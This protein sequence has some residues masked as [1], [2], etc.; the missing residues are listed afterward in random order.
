MEHD[1]RSKR[2]PQRYPQVHSKT[3][4]K[5]L[6]RELNILSQRFSTFLM[7]QASACFYLLSAG[8][9]RASQHMPFKLLLLVTSA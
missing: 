6:K 9:T 7:L 2:E 4:K 1:V 8:I 3:M 5:S